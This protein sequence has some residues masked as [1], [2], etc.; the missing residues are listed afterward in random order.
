MKNAALIARSIS[1][2]GKPIFSI[3]AITSS[4]CAPSVRADGSLKLGPS[5][6]AAAAGAEAGDG[7]DGGFDV[8]FD[9]VGPG[10]A[11]AAGVCAVADAGV[12]GALE[13]DD[14][15]AGAALG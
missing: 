15:A 7:V 8:V 4:R 13:V 9:V 6:D 3:F 5:A 10:A 14:E 2:L 12:E 1:A 11:G